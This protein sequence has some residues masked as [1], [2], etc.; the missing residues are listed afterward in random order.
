MIEYYMF[1]HKGGQPEY[2]DGLF[3]IAS[4]ELTIGIISSKNL[5]ESAGK[6]VKMFRDILGSDLSTKSFDEL[7]E[8]VINDMPDNADY[9]VLRISDTKVNSIRRGSVCGKI[10]KDGELKILPNGV[11]SLVDEDRLVCASESFFEHLPDEAIL[12]DSMFAESSKEW[13]DYMIRRISDENWLSEDNLSAVT[14][15]VRSGD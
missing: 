3:P 6:I 15:I 13:M 14:F 8:T 2:T 10:V 1:M 5:G 9:M 12:V 7:T 4:P 11:F